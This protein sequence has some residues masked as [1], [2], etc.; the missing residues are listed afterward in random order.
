MKT[1][2]SFQLGLASRERRPMVESGIAALERSDGLGGHLFMKLAV[3]ATRPR[4]RHSGRGLQPQKPPFVNVAAINADVASS[5]PVM[6]RT[7]AD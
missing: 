4:S 5:P 3:A 7:A 1:N 2:V 6:K